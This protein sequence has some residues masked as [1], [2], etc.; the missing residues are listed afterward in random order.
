[1]STPVD[2]GGALVGDGE[3]RD[4]V[5]DGLDM[6]DRRYSRLD[7]IGLGGRQIRRR[8]IKKVTRM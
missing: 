4:G 1:M 2:G 7:A 8:I 6:S 3:V 5:V